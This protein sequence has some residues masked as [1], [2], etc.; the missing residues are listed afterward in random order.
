MHASVNHY[1][2]A[3]WCSGAR[4]LRAVLDR[5]PPRDIEVVFYCTGLAGR[6]LLSAKTTGHSIIQ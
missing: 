3:R 2:L 1:T 6:K 4:I 5:L